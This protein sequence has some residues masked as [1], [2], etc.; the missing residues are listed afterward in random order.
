MIQNKKSFT[1]DEFQKKMEHYCVYQDRCHQEVERKMGEYQ[2]IPEA[3]EKI[4]LH[5]MQHNFL[6]EE[7]FS[8]SFAR[9]KFRIKNW[10]KQRIVRELNFRNISSYNIKTALKEINKEDY[11]QTIYRITENKNNNIF[12]KN[13]HK[14]KKKLTDFL[15]RK[16]FEYDLIFKTVKDIIN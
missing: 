4:L 5:L 10:G 9:G 8:K 12:E 3:Q 1:V 13:I 16:G 11:L 2:L 15:L 7:R 6:N 14:R